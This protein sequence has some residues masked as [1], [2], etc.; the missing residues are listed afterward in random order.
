MEIC[1]GFAIGDFAQNVESKWIGRIEKFVP[2][3]NGD[4]TAEMVGVDDFAIIFGGCT[5]EEALCYDDMRWHSPADLELLSDV[6][7]RK[8]DT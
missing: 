4:T 2:G 6:L 8:T 7:K 3:P 5:V 1:K